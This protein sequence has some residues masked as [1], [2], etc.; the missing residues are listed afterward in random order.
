MRG[1]YSDKGAVKIR[2]VAFFPFG[3]SKIGVRLKF[4]CGFISDKFGITPPDFNLRGE[5]KRI[6]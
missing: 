3:T 1:G 5:K 6:A 4:R 2:G